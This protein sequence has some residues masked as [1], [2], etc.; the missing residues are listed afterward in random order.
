MR[1][2]DHVDYQNGSGLGMNEVTITVSGRVGS[3]KSAV[4]GEIEILCRALGLQVEWIGGRDEKNL[5]GADWIHEIEMYKPV[6]KIVEQIES[7]APSPAAREAG[8][9][10]SEVQPPAGLTEREQFIWNLGHSAAAG[11][12][13]DAERYRWLREHH[14]STLTNE[15][16]DQQIA[17]DAALLREAG[18][19]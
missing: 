18:S 15:E 19:R 8:D 11:S 10:V 14:F 7:A 3:G 17:A 4:C 6:V 16:I 1:R 9:G 12:L 2:F 13:Q 5:T